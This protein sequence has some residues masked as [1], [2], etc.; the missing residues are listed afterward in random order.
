MNGSCDNSRMSLLVLLMLLLTVQTFEE[1]VFTST[2]QSNVELSHASQMT[3]TF[4]ER[5][6][7]SN[8]TGHSFFEGRSDRHE[9]DRIKKLSR[10]IRIVPTTFVVL[11]HF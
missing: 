9:A 10:S 1:K 2:R 6:M 11:H 8:A 4:I 3:M 7:N 5:S